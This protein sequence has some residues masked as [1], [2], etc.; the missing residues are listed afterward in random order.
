MT[1]LLCCFSEMCDVAVCCVFCDVVNVVD[2]ADV[3]DVAGV[4]GCRND[5][6]VLSPALMQ[7]K[8]LCEVAQ[9]MHSE[10]CPSQFS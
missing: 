9:Q 2:V 1:W 4:V 10:L 5:K 6:I 8:L 3:I 7:S